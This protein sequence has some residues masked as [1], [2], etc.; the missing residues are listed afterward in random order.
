MSTLASVI[1]RDVFANR[2]SAGIAGRLFYATD[3]SQLYRDNGASW[4]TYS[5]AGG[6]GSGTVTSVSG[7]TSG[8]FAV[9]VTNPTTTPAVAVAV[10]GTH[11]LPTATDQTNWNAKQTAGS[12]ITAL[13]G[14]VTATGP[15]SVAATLAN[16]AVTAGSY[17]NANITVDAKGRL[18][19]AANGSASG[20][21]SDA[22]VPTGTIDGTNTAFTLTQAATPAKSLILVLNG[23]VQ[24][25]QTSGGDY[26]LSGTGI[27]FT[28][29]PPTGSTL[30]AWYRY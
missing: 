10:D 24:N 26:A 22:E 16:T 5:G 12:Y 30:L 23:L 2:P 28:S 19:A 25:Q 13:T 27:T 14:D 3:T 21:F 17:T 9:S 7:A 18:T 8:G 1:L 15:G 11:Y 29:A 6:G 4:D 20:S